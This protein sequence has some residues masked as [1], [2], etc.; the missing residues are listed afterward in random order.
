[1]QHPWIRILCLALLLCSTGCSDYIAIELLR[2]GWSVTDVI[3]INNNGVVIGGEGGFGQYGS[4]IYRGGIY[5][6]LQPMPG[7]EYMFVNAINDAGDILGRFENPGDEARLFIYNSGTYEVLPSLGWDRL[8]PG[9]INNNKI[10]VGSGQNSNG[11]VKAFMYSNGHYTELLPPDAYTVEDNN[12]TIS[13]NDRAEVVLTGRY[14]SGN[15]SRVVIYREGE[16]TELKPPGL[17]DAFSAGI[18]ASGTVALWGYEST[19]GYSK[20]FIFNN[21]EYTELLPP[22]LSRSFV[23]KINDNGIVLGAGYDGEGKYRWFMYDGTA[24]TIATPPAI[25]HDKRIIYIEISSF[26][27]E[28]IVAGR[29]DKAILHPFLYRQKGFVATPFF[30]QLNE[31][32]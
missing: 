17:S 21:G 1:M 25:L 10:A 30:M 32:K 22:G 5:T 13:I 19:G 28:G 29:S 26:N 16:Y 27:N 4:F 11:I 8:R 9:D 7:W 2:P 23:L 31:R 15:R 3:D 24:Y 12:S 6:K 18:S 14:D 20:S